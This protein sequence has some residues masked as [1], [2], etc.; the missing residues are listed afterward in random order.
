M[1]KK[2]GS[3]LLGLCMLTMLLVPAF[4]VGDIS[5]TVD[6]TLADG[7]LTVKVQIPAKTDLATLETNLRYDAEKLTFSNVEY[8]VG[9]MNTYNADT[10]G[11]VK[12]YMVW[13][14]SQQDAATLVTVTFKVKEGAQGSTSLSFT[15]TA[16]TDS[17]DAKLPL[18]IGS[19]T[20]GSANAVQVQLTE[21]PQGGET[22]APHANTDENNPSTAG[23]YAAVGSAAFVVA[24]AAV[25]IS[26]AV[27][28]KKDEI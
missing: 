3:V 25:A 5:A 21:A 8:G 9:D 23:K 11:Q 2:L 27:K 20:A 28:R 10:A 14:N 16:A 24:A 26:V 6:T 4:A 18:V 1:L 12:L 19:S 15:D 17:T 22:T 7:T 13:S